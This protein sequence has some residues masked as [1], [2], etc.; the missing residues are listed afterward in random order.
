MD[1][2]YDSSLDVHLKRIEGYMRGCGLLTVPRRPGA[3]RAAL[4]EFLAA[5]VDRAVDDWVGL[6]GPALGIPPSDWADLRGAMREAMV[7]WVRHIANPDDVETYVYLRSHAHRAFISQF[8]PS[9][10]LSG[11]MKMR[12]IL[13]EYLQAEYRE[14]PEILH[15]LH[16]LF[17]QEF[18]ERML[19][20][21]DFF[22]E[23]RE[24]ELREQEASY[25]KSID[26]AP[27][28]IFRVDNE[29]GVVLDANLVA[30]R[31]L[32]TG[33]QHLIGVEMTELL[34][35]GQRERAVRL[36]AEARS[37]GH[38]SR[39]DLLL[40]G[41]DGELVPVF[42]N[43]GLIEYGHNHFFQVICVDVSDRRRLETQLIQSEKMAAIGQLAAGIAH[44]IRNPLGIITN[45]L[46]DL[47][48]IV[49]GGNP[50]VKEDLR[51][52]TEEMDRVQEIINNLLE[53]S[54]ESRAE[55]EEVDVNDL[56]RRTLQLMNKSLQNSDVR[57]ITDFAPLRTCRANQNALRQIFL[58]LI[59]NAVQAMPNGG[60]LR[61]RTAPLVGGW[62]Q[63]EFSD[64][65][66]GI[67]VEHL[68][69]IFNPF[70]TTKAPGQGTGLGLSVVHSVVKRYNGDI[71]VRS[72][73]NRGSTFTIEFPCNCAEPSF[74]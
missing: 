32:K 59:T 70:F 9:R 37:R 16:A 24:R 26:N 53:F 19:H 25:R 33:R 67:P 64:T 52:A 8:P 61:L 5:R 73:V 20:I 63:L 50:D 41:A 28:A 29:T 43:V 51:I 10:F 57:V 2:V 17:Q 46:Y 54:R 69:D 18:E 74:R 60:E 4:A 44:E 6:I 31:I 30:E 66:V 22:V 7:R 13:V 23:A 65:G 11:Q 56:L 49:D 72:Q 12:Q 58:N 35:S 45:A 71:Q 15:A 42:F 3:L 62:V 40:R 21:S 55:L 34:P 48:E 39:E 47:G 36:L 14:Q 27:A 1:P 68:R 38:A